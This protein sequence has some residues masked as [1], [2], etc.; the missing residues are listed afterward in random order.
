MKL[1]F[2]KYGQGEPF[3]ILHGLFGLSDNWQGIGK[4]LG[5]HFGVYLVDLRNHGLSPHSDEWSHGEMSADLFELMA[6]EGITEAIVLGHSL[7]GK[8]AMK[9]STEHPEKL[10]KLIVVDIAPRAYPVHHRE[11]LDALLSVDLY[12]IRSRKEAEQLLA[13]LDAGTRQFL[14]KNLYWKTDDKLD[15][16][17]NLR[18]I[19]EKIQGVGEEIVPPAKEEVRQRLKELPVLFV[20]GEHS[21]YIRDADLNQIKGLFPNAR[22]ETIAGAGHWVHADQPALFLERILSFAREY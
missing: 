20:R 10:K 4:Q 13:A 1:F 22:L 18:V 21:A 9:F 17:F 15:W 8:T 16:R 11:I 19:N 12:A 7:G 6:D 5:A 2:R 3:I 14:L